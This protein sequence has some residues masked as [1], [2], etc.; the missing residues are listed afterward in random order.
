MVGHQDHE[1]KS[2]WD[3]SGETTYAQ[4]RDRSW[5]I[6]DAVGSVVGGATTLLILGWI[7]KLV[8]DF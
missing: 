2:C 1:R 8:S 7:V 3:G 6:A 4:G 5:R